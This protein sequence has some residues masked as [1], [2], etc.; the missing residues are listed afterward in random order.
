MNAMDEWRDS[1]VKIFTQVF[2]TVLG[3]TCGFLA[4]L[5]FLI[6]IIEQFN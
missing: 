2:L 3:G 5:A 4:F 1:D 6:I